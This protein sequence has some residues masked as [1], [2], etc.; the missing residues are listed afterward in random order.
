VNAHPADGRLVPP[1]GPA[2]RTRLLTIADE[3]ARAGQEAP[4][5]A[6]RATVETWWAQEQAWLAG[7]VNVLRVHHDINNALVGVR[8]NAQLL[9]MAPVAE[10]PSVRDRLEVIIRESTRIKDAAIRIN[11]LKTSIAG[12]GPS[13]RAA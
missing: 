2:L 5:R 11:E 10:Q 6:L 13:A 7:V 4:S 1:P 12:P 8:G 3:L 9:L